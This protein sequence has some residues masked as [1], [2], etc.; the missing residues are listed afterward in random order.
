MVFGPNLELIIEFIDNVSIPEIQSLTLL[1]PL[2]DSDFDQ[3]DVDA[4]QLIPRGSRAK[5][6]TSNGDVFI[7]SGQNFIISLA[8]IFLRILLS[9][10]GLCLQKKSRI[11]GFIAFIYQFLIGLMFFDYQ[12]ICISEISLFNYSSLRK[13]S[14]KYTHSLLL[15]ISITLLILLDFYQG[16]ELLRTK[17][18]EMMATKKSTEEIDASKN[19]RMV[20]DKYTEVIQMET[21]GSQVYV[22]LVDNVRYFAIQVVI[23]SL[24]LLD[25]T[26][27]VLISILNFFYLVYFLRLVFTKKVFSSKLLLVKMI[28]QECSIMVLILVITIFCFTE[29][30]RTSSS[31]FSK[32]LEGL[33]MI[34]IAGAGGSELVLML[35]ALFSDMTSCCRKKKNNKK[36]DVW[37]SKGPAKDKGDAFWKGWETSQEIQKRKKQGQQENLDIQNLFK[38]KRKKKNEEEKKFIEKNKMDDAWELDGNFGSANEKEKVLEQRKP[39]GRSRM[40]QRRKSRVGSRMRQKGKPILGR[41]GNSIGGMKAQEIEAKVEKKSVLWDKK[42]VK[43]SWL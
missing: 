38:Q 18:V 26:Q 7:A 14:S 4:Y 1:S 39:M 24:Q 29:T 28:V 13:S 3:P 21:Y 34:S 9:L 8:I 33:A 42:D 25:R 31:I 20:L 12:F 32:G 17:A 5:V 22:V 10:L 6:T 16:Y 36:K 43:G 40:K 35:T 11:L 37:P 30:T 23:A 2:K 41:R 15:S 19:D 27:A